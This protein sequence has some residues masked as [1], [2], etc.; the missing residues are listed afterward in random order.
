MFNARE[1][2]MATLVVVCLWS[3]RRASNV[4]TEMQPP[5][6]E[7]RQIVCERAR[8]RTILQEERLER[9]SDMVFQR[10]E[11]ARERARKVKEERESLFY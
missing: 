11:R 5:I 8:G 7:G 6:R 4:Q 10:E 1:E 9:T 2:G 3:A